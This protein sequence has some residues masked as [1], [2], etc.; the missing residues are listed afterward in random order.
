MHAVVKF[1][2]SDSLATECL[3]V[4]SGARTPEDAALQVFQTLDG[5]QGAQGL[6]GE[7]RDDTGFQWQMCIHNGVTTLYLA[8]ESSDSCSVTPRTI[9]KFCEKL[10]Q[11]LSISH[12]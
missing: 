10:C 5:L 3:D 8:V 7:F 9:R 11:L 2:A 6:E 12:R 1:S 4:C